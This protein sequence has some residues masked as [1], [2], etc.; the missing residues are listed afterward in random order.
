M[1]I[2]TACDVLSRY[3][4]PDPLRQPSTSAIA[5]T[6]LQLFSQHAY[7]PEHILTDKGSAFTS[8]V[9]TELMSESGIKI[10][11]ATLKH[12]QTIRR[13]QRTHQKLKKILKVNVAADKPH[14]D[15]YVKLA[16]MGHNSTYH[17]SLKCTPAEIFR[18]RIPYKTLYLKF[19]NPLQRNR[20]KVHVH[21]LLDEINRKYKDT[22]ANIFEAFHK[23]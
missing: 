8:P 10:N 18:G 9:L 7:V 12:A 2:F 20:T 1:L 23:S 13:V 14:W 4:F 6:L 11:H 5:H 15:R 21:T 3:F 17:Q 16:I 19:R 22:T